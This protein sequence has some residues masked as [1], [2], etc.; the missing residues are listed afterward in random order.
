MSCP[1]FGLC[2]G[3]ITIDLPYEESLNGKERELQSL[4]SPLYGEKPPVYE[5]FYPSPKPYE[6]RNKM[7]FSFG[8][9]RKDGPLTLGMHR[10][11]SF[12]DIITVSG[13]QIMDGDF[14]SILTATR[15]YF[16]GAPFYHKKSRTGYLRHLVIRK[17][18]HTGEILLDLVTTTQKETLPKEESEF[19]VGWVERVKSLPLSGKLAGILHTK[20]DALADAVID[21]GTETLYGKNFFQEALLGLRFTVTPF[22]FFQ[23]NS[24]SAE[25][26][27]KKVREYVERAEKKER[28]FDLYC[29][30]G[31]IAQL[32]HAPG[33]KVTGVEIVPEAVLAAK[34]NAEMNGIPEK[35]CE[36][37]Q[38]DVLKVLDSLAEPPDVIVLD[39][40][41]EGVHPKAL[42]K[43]LDYGAKTLVYVSCKPK[44]L[45]RD[46]ELIL[47]KGYVLERYCGVDQF[48]HTANME[49]VAVF[50]R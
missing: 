45:A 39:P 12:Y 18:S 32:L 42:P 14:R 50:N 24:Y 41:R 5:G 8:N 11:K 15:D 21:E 29:G 40:P 49:A 31:T 4:L 37:L 30:T 10:K 25:V 7:E 19:L 28:I 48:P 20:N 23:T 17:A 13:C 3:C 6:Y 2:G 38:G 36:F 27:Y 33:R 1:H 46:M 44:S 16:D 34:E 47:A 35:E 22:S 9:D 26:L 43:I